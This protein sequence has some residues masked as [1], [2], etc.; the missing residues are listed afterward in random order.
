MGMGGDKGVEGSSKK[1]KG[2][3]DMDTSVI[4]CGE[5]SVREVNGNEKKPPVNSEKRK[6]HYTSVGGKKPPIVV[7]LF[8][9]TRCCLREPANSPS[10]AV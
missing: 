2:L 10:P 3:M 7:S 4:D 5:W 6:G 1:V 8:Y 9:L